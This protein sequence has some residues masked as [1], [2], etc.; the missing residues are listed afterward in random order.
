MITIQNHS[1]AIRRDI[2][3]IEIKVL[4]RIRQDSYRVIS[5]LNEKRA[6]PIPLKEKEVSN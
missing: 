5:F 3:K 1:N 6:I 2:R 4:R